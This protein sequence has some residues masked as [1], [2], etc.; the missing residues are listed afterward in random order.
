MRISRTGGDPND[1]TSPAAKLLKARNKVVGKI[2]GLLSQVR[3]HADVV[4][5]ELT[6]G[7]R[8]PR[9]KYDQ[10]IQTTQQ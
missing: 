7:G 4:P 8:F 10:M 5:L 9:E 1:K 6:I 2:I 3:Q